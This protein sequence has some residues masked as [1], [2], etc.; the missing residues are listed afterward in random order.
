ML[1]KLLLISLGGACGALGRFGLAGAVQKSLDSGF[2]WGTAAVN[3]IGCCLFGLF[4]ALAVER[5]ALN[6][7]VRAFILVGFL[8]SFTTFST[9]ISETGQLLTDSG[10]IV[11]L[12]NAAFQVISG[13]GLFFL[14]VA[15][16]R[17]FY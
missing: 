5:G 12:G 7:D 15:V 10:L 3:L 8:G 16:G 2:P 1:Q 6:A 14:G 11:G 4:W 9:F 13:I 17:L